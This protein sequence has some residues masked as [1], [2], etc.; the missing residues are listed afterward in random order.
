MFVGL[1]TVRPPPPAGVPVLVAA[2]A[3]APGSVLG[4]GDVVV[5]SVP[6]PARQPG[7]VTTS[8]AAVGRR[9][10]SPLLAGE[11]VTSSRFVPRTVAEGLGPGEVALH[12]LLADPAA[13]DLVVPGHRV[14][15]YS[16]GGGDALAAGARVLA[17]DPLVADPATALGAGPSG[18]RGVVLA[19]PGDAARAVLG[20]HGGLEGPPVVNVAVVA[21]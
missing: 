18:G 10:G 4:V 16:T 8:A 11:A 15:V 21:S 3:I 7:A 17:L 2:R 12:V 6:L 9:V 5:R 19:L 20:G 14:A 1:Q 13:V